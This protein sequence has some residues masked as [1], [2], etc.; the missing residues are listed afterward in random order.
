MPRPKKTPEQIAEMRERILNATMDLLDRVG[1]AGLSIRKIGKQLGVSHMVLYTYFENRNAVVEALKERWLGRL[2]AQ[3]ADALRE[4]TA[5]D[6][7]A[8]LRASLAEIVQFSHE[9]PRI[10]RLAWVHVGADGLAHERSR[11]TEEHLDHLSQLVGLCIERGQ[12]VD[13]DP[14]MAAAVALCIVSG[15]QVLYHSERLTDETLVAQLEP[16][17]LQTAMDYLTG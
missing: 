3:R 12:C 17:A 2:R 4:A 14:R 10:Y 8:V 6:A 1:T 5:G 11:Y 7:L 13:R 15:P 16:E 9:H